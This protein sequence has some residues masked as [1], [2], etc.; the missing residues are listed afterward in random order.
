MGLLLHT[1]DDGYVGKRISCFRTWE[2][3]STIASTRPHPN[4][5]RF[6]IVQKATGSN[7]VE[8]DKSSS[9][10]VAREEKVK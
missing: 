5:F 7:T 4:H 2:I 3:W 1:Q 10:A 8:V 6:F 9:F